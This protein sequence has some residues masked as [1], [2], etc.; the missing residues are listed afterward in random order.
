MGALLG[1]FA[2]AAINAIWLLQSSLRGLGFAF[3]VYLIVW[4]L[5]FALV[6]DDALVFPLRPCL[7]LSRMS[8]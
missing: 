7:A 6:A 3:A 5:G 2:L 4:G 1:A 8:G